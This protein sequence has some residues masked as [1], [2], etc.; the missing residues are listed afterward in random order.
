MKKILRLRFNDEAGV[1]CNRCPISTE[2]NSGY[3]CAGIGHKPPCPEEGR[4]AE[5]P[6]EDDQLPETI[7]IRTNYDAYQETTEAAPILMDRALAANEPQDINFYRVAA[8]R[9]QIEA[10]RLFDLLM[11]GEGDQEQES[12]YTIKQARLRSAWK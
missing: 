1:E 11:K 8:R 4:L 5:C 10:D 2:C 9:N 3:F 6:L 7:Y 12:T